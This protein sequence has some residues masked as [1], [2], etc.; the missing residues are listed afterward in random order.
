[1]RHVAGRQVF[2]RVRPSVPASPVQYRVNCP[3]VNTSISAHNCCRCE[4]SSERNSLFFVRDGDYRSSQSPDA[5]IFSLFAPMTLRMLYI[6]LRETNASPSIVW[7]AIPSSSDVADILCRRIRP[8]AVSTRCR[9]KKALFA[10]TRRESR[11]HS[12]AGSS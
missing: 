1:M 3:L 8:R 2:R 4:T 7:L 12:A 5:E 11:C 9:C 6:S 10:Q